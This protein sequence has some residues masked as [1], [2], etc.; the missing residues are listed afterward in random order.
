MAL[1]LPRGVSEYGPSDAIALSEIKAVIEE[2]FKRFGFYPIDSP[3]LELLETLDVKAY[4]EESKKELYVI[5]GGVDALRYDLTVP[6]ARYI[7][8]NKD[9]PLPFK[10]YQIGKVW[11]MDEPQKMRSREI[12]QADVDVVGSTEISS[13]AEVIAATALALDALKVENYSILINSRPLLNAILNL[14]NVPE[15]S[16]DVAIRTIDKMAKIGAAEVGAQMRKLGVSQKDCD[17]LLGFIT[18]KAENGELLDS[19]LV[20]LPGAKQET[21]SLKQL[22]ALLGTYGIRGTITI[23]LSL[24]RGLEYYTGAVWEFVA[25]ENGKRLPSIGSGGR[26][27]KLIGIYLKKDIPAVGSSLG[28][29]RIFEVIKGGAGRKSY[30][31]VYVGYIKKENLEYATQ[32]ANT[33]RNSGMYVDL[34]LTS[35]NI[36]KQMEYANSLGVPYTIII[37]NIE[38][39]AQKL[40]LRDMSTGDEKLL[41]IEECI[42]QLKE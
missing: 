27:D 25:Y 5:D 6:L 41:S 8:M 28:V 1:S 30:A 29:G 38:R 20:S 2:I 37:G 23:D 39:E 22:L 31:K 15:A 34:N 24:A 42:K 19:L 13:E 4:G 26:Y 10:R 16:H 7:A 14:F 21:E 12:L 11:R 35:R 36:G 40:K 18:N 17:G 3:S 9:L 32:V 33:L